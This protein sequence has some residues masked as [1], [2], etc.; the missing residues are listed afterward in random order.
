MTVQPIAKSFDQASFSQYI[1]SEV[2]TKMGVWR[3]RG[4]VLHNTYLP[5]LANFYKGGHGVISGTQRVKNMW[6]S[7]E[8]QGWPGGPHL[9]VTDREIIAANPLWMKG[10]HSPSYNAA[11]WGCELAGDFSTEK[12]PDALRDNAV[13]AIAALYAMIGQVPNNDTFHF[14]GED[15]RTTH[16]GCPGKNV[17]T[18]ADWIKMIADAMASLHPG[19]HAHAA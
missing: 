4:M 17:G 6:T 16:R 13:H 2:A 10:T 9:V 18:K 14:H 8:Q 12:M 11:Y 19:G 7:Y 3:P 5:T 15:P 1:E